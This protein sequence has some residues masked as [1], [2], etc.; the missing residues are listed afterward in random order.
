MVDA[1]EKVMRDFELSEQ[2]AKWVILVV[3]G[4][5]GIDACREA[6][7]YEN[8]K[9]Y[10][11]QLRTLIAN[12]KIDKAL[13][14]LGRNLKDEYEKSAI[15]V[16]KALQEI[17]FAPSTAVRDRLAALKEL[18][19][20]NPELQTLKRKDSDDREEEEL[21]ERVNAWLSKDDTGPE[22]GSQ[23]VDGA[24]SDEGTGDK[25]PDTE[26]T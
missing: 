26:A 24:G 18:A 17:A 23:V 6:Y 16:I 1:Q 13:K 2:Q 9:N 3:A 21:A 7:N 19:Q 12:P 20:Y 22:S 5:S 11:G 25:T 8:D 10:Y 14:G 15:S 4:R